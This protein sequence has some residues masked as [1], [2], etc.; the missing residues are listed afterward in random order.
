MIGLTRAILLA[1]IIFAS[2]SGCTSVRPARASGPDRVEINI[3]VNDGELEITVRN[4]GT[5][6]VK[7]YN[8]TAIALLPDDPGL[9]YVLQDQE[10]KRQELCAFVE[11]STRSSPV[12]LQVGKS[13]NSKMGIDFLAS[14]FCLAPGEYDVRVI[15]HMRDDEAPDRLVQTQSQ[16]LRLLLGSDR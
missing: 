2:I 1:A 7:L 10:G 12:P 13:V 3:A 9:E 14:L 16:S 15:L 4:A 6:E 8:P 11:P 5:E